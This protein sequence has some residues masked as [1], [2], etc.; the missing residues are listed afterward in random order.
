MRYGSV[1]TNFGEWIAFRLG[2]VP[3]PIL[4]TLLGDAIRR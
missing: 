4:D 2:K 1:A 3:L